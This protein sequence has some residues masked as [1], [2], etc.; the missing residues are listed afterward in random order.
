MHAKHPKKYNPDGTLNP[1]WKPRKSGKRKPLYQSGFFV[2]IDGEGIDTPMPT[3]A[4]EGEYKNRGTTKS[5]TVFS[6]A[7]QHIYT[8]LSI[9]D[10]SRSAVLHRG[11]R[12]LGSGECLEF[13]TN[14]ARF[15]GKK[16]IYISFAFGYDATH[17]LR[18]ISSREIARAMA[19]DQTIWGRYGRYF[20]KYYH[21]RLLHI[22]RVKDPKN[23]FKTTSNGQKTFDTDVSM[24]IWDT[25]GYFQCSFIKALALWGIGTTE[26]QATIKKGKEQRGSFNEVNTQ[27]IIDYNTLELKLLNQMMEKVREAAQNIDIILNRYDGAGSVAAAIYKKELPKDYIRSIELSDELDTVGHYAYF[28][29][30]IETIQYGNASGSRYTRG[31]YRSDICSAYPS[32]IAELPDLHTALWH[33]YSGQTDVFRSFALYK[34]HWKFKRAYPFYPFP[35]R[36]R[37]GNVSFPREGY[38]WVWGAELLAA[39]T[40]GILDHCTLKIEE[41]WTYERNNQGNTEATPAGNESSDIISSD[42][43]PFQF[44]RRYYTHRQAI[45]RR[46]QAGIAESNDN[47]VSLIIKLGLNSLYGKTAQRIG[48]DK[49]KH[50]RPSFYNILYAGYITAVTRSKL[51]SAAFPKRDTIISLATDGILSTEPLDVDEG[52]ELGQWECD[53]FDG[54]VHVQSGVYWLKQGEKW[55]E[56]SR[57]IDKVTSQEYIIERVQSVLTKWT[58]GETHTDY[59]LHR[60]IGLKAAFISPQYWHHRG[61]WIEMVKSVELYGGG[62]KRRDKEKEPKP[63]LK[64]V[65]T[66]ANSIFASWDNLSTKAKSPE[67]EYDQEEELEPLDT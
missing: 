55:I 8:I 40:S 27:E 67:E 25:F 61:N 38:N 41:Y 11:N 63:H 2:S 42:S 28:G 5:K 62:S 12:R 3:Q 22:I 50:Q 30:R 10:N 46:I 4:I 47:G 66:E 43:Y 17:I 13:L 51:F 16:A 44:I 60:L 21:R 24:R 6:E 52:I 65:K 9:A 45:K 57:G 15:F 33:H 20:I 36:E 32:V 58:N 19:N 54:I 49:E 37:T 14:Q 59:H 1:K 64:L 35:Y 23:P 29:G 34:I 48:Y 53:T 18:D 39:Q 56:Y 31:I 7:H 26:E